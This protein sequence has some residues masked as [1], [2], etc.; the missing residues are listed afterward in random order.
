LQATFNETFSSIRPDLDK[1]LNIRLS[2]AGLVY[3]HFGEEVIKEVLKEF[4][5]ELTEQQMKTV[6]KKIYTSF[7]QEI[8][9]IDNGVPQFDGEPKYSINSHLSAR[10]KKF[11]LDWTE[12]KTPQEIDE[13][14]QEAT[15]YVGAEFI[16]KLKYFA[17]SWLPARKIV[18]KAVESRFEV[19]NSGSI[20]EL[21]R[22]C[23]WQEHLRQ[24]ESEREGVE[25][26]YVL[27]N[28]SSDINTPDFR[29]QGVSVADGSFVLRKPLKWLGLRDD[30]LA[31]KSGIAGARFVHATGFIGGSKTRE[32][33][34]QMA[35]KSLEE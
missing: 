29:V 30:E 17:I 9:G 14:F 13:S 28:G 15:K 32:G 4:N 1:N 31:E 33:C 10:V 26:K 22:F 2:S 11:N 20:I 19:H 12:T 18:E 27:F 3:I 7:I 23:P 5:V 21:D 24:I 34:L 25:I 6:F 16:D 35:I 8:D